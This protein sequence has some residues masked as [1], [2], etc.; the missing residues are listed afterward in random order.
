MLFIITL[1]IV[2]VFTVFISI[3]MT[4]V[5]RLRFVMDHVLIVATL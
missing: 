3:L 2:A 1:N 5:V 4:T